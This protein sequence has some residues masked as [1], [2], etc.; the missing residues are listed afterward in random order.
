MFEDILPQIPEISTSA[1]YWYVRTDGGALYEPF[2]RS[3]SIAI[4]YPLVSLSFIQELDEDEKVGLPILKEELRKH[5]PP[6]E[7][8]DGRVN[9]LSGLHA[10]Q[11]WKFV[12]EMK[13]GDIVIIPSPKG[14]RLAIGFVEDKP[15]FE[16]ALTL[17]AEK[18]PEFTKRRS[19]NW[20]RGIDRSGIN[21]NL[22]KLFLN[23]QTLIDASNYAGWIDPLL[24]DL[25]KKGE[26]YHLVLRVRTEEHIKAQ[27]LFKTCVGLLDL[28]ADF[29]KLESLDSET[30]A[31]ETRINLNSPG[32]VEFWK[33]GIQL[34]FVIG[35]LI[36][37]INGGGITYE[38]AKSK[39]SLKTDGILSR[40]NEFLNDHVRRES[41]KELGR[42]LKSLQIMD[43]KQISDLFKSL[44][45]K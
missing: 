6:K 15:A 23:P 29:A 18:F 44:L 11:L 35:L 9:D 10:A 31:I 1:K 4:G 16:D 7:G 20:L 13:A 37:F 45:K 41:V 24:Y 19:V 36:V 34:I 25:F 32:D 30:D 22:F 12:R 8:V 14:E 21:P 26:D 39:F 40:L 38:D 42:K 28:A 17:G 2:R 43:P 33:N 3:Q 5:Y 27:P